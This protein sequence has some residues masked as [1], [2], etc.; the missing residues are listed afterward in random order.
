MIT[1]ILKY[2]LFLT[3]GKVFEI[4]YGDLIGRY[5]NVCLLR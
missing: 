2:W 5:E 1:E 3:G 4:L